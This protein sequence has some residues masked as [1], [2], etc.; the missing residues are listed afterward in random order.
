[1]ISERKG[2]TLLEVIIALAVVSI[3]LVTLL[4]LSN[5][6][7]QVHRKLQNVTTATLLAQQQMNWFEAESQSGTLSFVE[8]NGRFEDP[9]EQF[10]WTTRF[11]DTL[12]EAVKM[13]TVSVSWDGEEKTSSVDLTSFL[14]EK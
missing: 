11:E 8:Q 2:F 1:M 12:V 9:F 3:S 7:L 13:I 4:G 14:M 5:R 6:C 10:L